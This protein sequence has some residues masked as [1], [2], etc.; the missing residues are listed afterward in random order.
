MEVGRSWNGSISTVS[1][2][3]LTSKPV[4]AHRPSPIQFSVMGGGGSASASEAASL[5][6]RI[7][8]VGLSLASAI[9]TAA[10][11][12]CVYRD[13]GVPAGTVSYADYNSFK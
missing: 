1:Q 8:T 12:Q 4:H 9:M 3:C 13:T 7:A 5:V 6:F 10:S 11:T 2:K